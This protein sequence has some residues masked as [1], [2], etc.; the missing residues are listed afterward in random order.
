MSLHVK[1]AVLEYAGF[2]IEDDRQYVM[3]PRQLEITTGDVVT[4]YAGATKRSAR[5]SECDLRGDQGL[6]HFLRRLSGGKMRFDLTSGDEGVTGVLAF[7]YRHSAASAFVELSR[8]IPFA[9]KDFYDPKDRL[10]ALR[11]HWE[12]LSVANCQTPEAPTDGFVPEHLCGALTFNQQKGLLQGAYE[13]AQLVEQ[14]NDDMKVLVAAYRKHRLDANLKTVDSLL[15]T[16]SRLRENRAAYEL[17]NASA[18]IVFNAESEY[19]GPIL[20]DR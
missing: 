12:H 11:D 9:H 1:R 18:A 5:L 4:F 13:F 2:Y 14:R 20:S 3:D 7:S 16:E 17:L 19:E 6:E 15:S 10:G 8:G